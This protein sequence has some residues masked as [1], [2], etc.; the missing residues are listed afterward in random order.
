MHLEKKTLFISTVLIFAVLPLLLQ[1][2][3]GINNQLTNP[4]E[5]SLFWET[6]SRSAT[7][8][9][10]NILWIP[11]VDCRVHNSAHLVPIL[12]QKIAG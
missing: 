1:E 2:N 4:N 5:L 3:S 10:P 11:K 8:E 9:F 12:S 6:A 7:R